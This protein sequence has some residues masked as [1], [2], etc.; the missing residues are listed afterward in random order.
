MLTG[1]T[2]IMSTAQNCEGQPY[3]SLFCINLARLLLKGAF[4]TSRFFVQPQVRC[5]KRFDWTSSFQ[6]SLYPRMQS[7]TQ[8]WSGWAPGYRCTL[9]AKSIAHLENLWESRW[10][11]WD[12]DGNHFEEANSNVIPYTWKLHV[13]LF[14]FPVKLY[15]FS[16]FNFKR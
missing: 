14:M 15:W 8:E 5:H 1:Y 16:V 11:W 7:Q 3:Q 12:E 13:A 10:E 2:F 6:N 9:E 4:S